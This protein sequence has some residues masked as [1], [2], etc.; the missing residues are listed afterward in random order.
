MSYTQYVYSLCGT[1]ALT[2]DIRVGDGVM[3]DAHPSKC[4][5]A[6]LLSLMNVVVLTTTTVKLYLVPHCRLVILTEFTLGLFSFISI[7]ALL[8]DWYRTKVVFQHMDWSP[9][10]C[11]VTVTLVL[12]VEFR[13]ATLTPVGAV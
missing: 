9:D 1:S 3:D 12:V 10:H 13:I 8:S 11:H 7:G 4:I 5:L 2:T 6:V